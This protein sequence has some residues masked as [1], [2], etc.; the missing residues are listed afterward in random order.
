MAIDDI[1]SLSGKVAVVT[2]GSSGI[3]A[4]S[5]RLI[6]AAGA[7]VVV[8][9]NRGADRAAAL[10]GELPGEGH[11]AMYLPLEDTPQ[12]RKVAAAVRDTYGRADILVNSAGF[13]RMVPHH[14][15]EALDDDLIDAVLT[16]NV[17]GPFATIRAFVPLLR[18][19][20]D[21]V[22]VNISSGAAQSGTGS[23]I[24][25]GASK[26]AL[27]TMSMALARVL[28]PEIRVIV[29]A[30]GMVHTGFVPGRTEEMMAAAAMAT[31]LK[32]AI[33]AHDVAKAVMACITHLTHTTGSIVS[34]DAGRHL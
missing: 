4:A 27:N 28:G 12:I 32:R 11:K 30:P 15:Q 7:R 8:G 6:A 16:A 25:Y 26:A 29:V 3:G 9:Y 2:G 21:G 10:I 31:P 14:D 23:S 18:E 33:E 13:T 19:S 1:S 22:I 34:V 5:V 17:R 20:G 24:I